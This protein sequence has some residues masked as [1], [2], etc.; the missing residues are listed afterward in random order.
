[1]ATTQNSLASIDARSFF[2]RALAY[3]VAHGVLTESH[4]DKIRQDGPKG[5]VQ[6]ANHFGTAYLQASPLITPD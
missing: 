4:L 2:A 5:I 6:I 3:G 1:M